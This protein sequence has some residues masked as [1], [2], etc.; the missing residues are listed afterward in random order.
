MAIFGRGFSL[1]STSARA[2][3]AES[4]R[5]FAHCAKPIPQTEA[6]QKGP[7][8]YDIKQILTVPNLNAQSPMTRPAW[9]AKQLQGQNG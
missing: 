1:L 5:G 3:P 7:I 8:G 9:Q 4:G 2:S 6:S